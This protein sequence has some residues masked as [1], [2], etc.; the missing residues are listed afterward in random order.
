M[1]D[2]NLIKKGLHKSSKKRKCMDR[3]KGIGGVYLVG[4]KGEEIHG[5]KLQI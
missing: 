1:Q 2:S 5:Q 4:S 3:K